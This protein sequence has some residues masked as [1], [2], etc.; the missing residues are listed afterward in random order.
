MTLNWI[1][2]SV[3]GQ[4]TV[5]AADRVALSCEGQD[6]VTYTGLRDLAG[7]YAAGLSQLGVRRGDRIGYLLFNSIEYQPLFFAGAKLG[8]IAVRL[9]FRLAPEEL[10]FILSDSGCETLVVN[11]SLVEKVESIIADTDVKNT[12]VLPD[13][14]APVPSWAIPFD[15]F[16]L[17]SENLETPE[18]AAL[19]DDPVSLLYTS[20]TTGLP[21]GAIW[22]HAIMTSCGLMQAAKWGFNKDTVTLTPGPMY[23]AGG[24][25][26]LMLPALL[27]HGTAAFLGSTGF[28]AERLLELIRAEQVTDAL[29]YSFMMYDFLRLPDLEE[30]IPSSLRRI[31]CGGDTMMPWVG[32]EIR[33]RLP[34]V[35]L[36]QLYGLS[37][38]G[39]V[40]TGLDHDD[41]LDNP[42]S[43]GRP[44]PLTEVRLMD[45]NGEPVAAEEVGEVQL[46]SPSVC[47]GYWRKPEAT[48]D[49]FD[50]GWL[51]T[52]DLG[53]VNE[54]GFLSLS[55]RAKD[56]IRS[57]GE[58]IYPAEVEAVL[59]DHAGIEDAAV[60]AVPDEKYNEVG[61]AVLVVDPSSALEDDDLRSFCRER[62]AG[63]KVPKHFVRVEALPRN[64]AGKVLK[65][66]LRER[67]AT[68]V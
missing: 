33:R 41:F 66:E 46:R 68:A 22:T 12:V 18:S 44:L 47:A 21:K 67:Y 51:R 30:M 35:E 45:E 15:Q 39:A 16:L 63:Y 19:P 42:G 59:T 5:G 58:N 26:A 27:S 20:G 52:G 62:L 55:G 48:R 14:D 61:L 9:N 8:A 28:T 13:S 56:M 49:V 34:A 43:I 4:S 24:F 65:Y 38:G 3:C 7:R 54:E 40:A 36:T 2:D 37:E 57:G 10:R 11:S 17:D 23:H 60:I 32:T 50:D 53:K 64:G 29:V 31:Y 1:L 25:E 6:S